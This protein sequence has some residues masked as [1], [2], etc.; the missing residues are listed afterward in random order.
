MGTLEA[1]LVI[2]ATILL[3]GFFA[4][5]ETAIISCSKVRIRHLAKRGSWRARI[6]EGLMNSPEQF[7]SV[8]L[9][10][11]NLTVIVCTATATALAVYKLGN[12]GAVIATVVMTPIILIFGEV[13]P[14]S[15]FHYHADRISIAVSP[16]LKFF[17]YLLW[18][19]VMPTT[20][21]VRF[22]MR[23]TGL[24]ESRFN[25]LTS[26][27]ELI[28]LYWKGR[29][30]GSAELM[31]RR[32]MDWVFQLGRLS[33][34]ELMVPLSKVVFFSQDST[35]GEVIEESNKHSFS[36]YPVTDPGGD[37]V[38][39]I[40]SLIDLLGLD[41]GET[42]ASIMHPPSFANAEELVE[43]LLV[44]MKNEVLHM[45][46]ITDDGGA[47]LGM[48]TLE[49]ILESVIGDIASDY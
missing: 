37:R 34:G 2:L 9:V 25:L 28:H 29:E 32:I 46:I 10:G 27:E 44:R 35:I 17:T 49:D 20:L 39:G 30:E 21:F 13:I 24:G 33:V 15:A 23:L 3:L 4:G 40:I 5:S 19:I 18:P 14:K 6:L 22:L 7:F 41:G 45:A 36:H 31:E 47:V 43:D 42:L 26:R 48:A 12:S 16:A 1:V 11:T 8:V 38:V